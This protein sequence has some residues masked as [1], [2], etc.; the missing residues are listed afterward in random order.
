MKKLI[1][2]LLLIVLFASSCTGTW[3]QDDKQAFFDACMDD[4]NSWVRDPAKSKTYCEC[5]T[6]KVIEK[7]PNVMDAIEQIE[8]ISKDADIQTCRIPIMK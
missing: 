3:N 7:Y 4:A 6:I 8:M 5:V 1:P 2:L